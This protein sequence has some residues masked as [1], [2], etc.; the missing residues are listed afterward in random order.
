M[1]KIYTANVTDFTQADYTEMYSLLDCALKQK[2][3]FKK[4]R[5]DKLLSLAGYILLYN[6]VKELYGKTDF[7]ITINEHGKPLCDFCYFNISHSVER[8][9][10]A[11]S[12]VPIGID[13]QKIYDIKL[14]QKYKFFNQKENVY[15]NQSRDFLS[16]RYIEIFTKKE[17]AIKM[18]GL[19]IANAADIDT[20]SSEF[21][22]ETQKIDDFLIT[23]CRKN[24]QIM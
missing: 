19:S 9:V 13:I 14:R 5:T 7:N 6:G 4:K 24:L 23:V 12:D 18:L 20:F 11:F 10:C 21:Y 3:D 15:V 1:I 17:A 8:V 16:E 2:I 22:F